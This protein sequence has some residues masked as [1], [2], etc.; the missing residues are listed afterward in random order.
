MQG[1]A[2]LVCYGY[3]SHWVDEVDGDCNCSID[4]ATNQTINFEGITMYMS[5]LLGTIYYQ[6]YHSM[7]INHQMLGVYVFFR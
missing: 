1:G 7:M 5:E 2:A 6:Y 3:S 4:G